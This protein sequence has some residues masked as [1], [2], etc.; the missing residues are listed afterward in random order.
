MPYSIDHPFVFVHSQ[1]GGWERLCLDAPEELCVSL[2]AQKS[3][4]DGA[5]AMAGEIITAFSSSV[6]DYSELH[7]Q[8]TVTVEGLP[9]YWVGYTYTRNGKTLE[10][11]RLFVVAGKAGFEIAAEGEPVMMDLYRVVIKKMLESFRL[12]EY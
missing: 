10:G 8:S 9:A 12:K 7:R 6:S 3:R 1:S 2:Q 11:S 4:W 5:E